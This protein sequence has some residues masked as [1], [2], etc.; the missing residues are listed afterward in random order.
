MQTKIISYEQTY[1]DKSAWTF[2]IK[3]EIISSEDGTLS[4]ARQTIRYL[5]CKRDQ[6]I[7]EQDLYSGTKIISRPQTSFRLRTG[8]RNEK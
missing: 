7:E 2:L 3:H 6:R 5:T 1:R 8:L 4:G